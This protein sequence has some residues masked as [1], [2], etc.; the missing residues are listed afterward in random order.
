[1][2]TR[3]VNASDKGI[4]SHIPA[5]PNSSGNKRN[6]GTSRANPLR[7][8]RVKAGLISSR[9][10]KYPTMHTLNVKN[11]IPTA[12]YGNPSMAIGAAGSVFPTKKWT[13]ISGMNKKTSVRKTPAA[14]AVANSIRL[15]LCTLSRLCAK[16]L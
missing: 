1:M 13:S 9:L 7:N 12:K 11:S 14:K 15:I 3:K 16:W 6:A 4:A 5:I 10:W 2:L 8:I